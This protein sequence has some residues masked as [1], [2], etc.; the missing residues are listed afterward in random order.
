[1][2]VELKLLLAPDDLEKLPEIEALRVLREG[3][4]RVQR[5][6]TRYYDTPARDLARAGIALRVRRAGEAWIQTIKAGGRSAGGL[7]ERIELEWTIADADL[8]F[9]RLAD[10]PYQ[11]FFADAQLRQALQPVYETD[12]ERV[13]IQLV[14]PDGARAELALDRGEVRSGPRAESISEAEIE[15][16]GGDAA[17]LFDLAAVIAQHVPLR[18]GYLSKAERGD[19]L[20]TGRERP[21]AKAT[22][23]ELT[24]ECT[25]AQALARIGLS[26]LE[27]IQANEAGV[28][29]ASD[30][31]YLHQLRVGLRRLRVLVGLL[32]FVAPKSAFA[33]DAKALRALS[34][35]LN[36]ARDWDV[37]VDEMLPT[38]DQAMP[39]K[40]EIAARAEKLRGKHRAKAREALRA[41]GYGQLM[42]RLAQRFNDPALGLGSSGKK[43]KR[44]ALDAPVEDLAA[45]ALERYDRKLRKAGARLA[46][47]D[48]KG[49][50]ALRIRAKKLRY[51]A[52]FFAALYPAGRVKP[53][54]AALR[55]LQ[56][57]LGTLG[58][59]AQYRRLSAK[60]VD[61]DAAEAFEAI[62]RWIDQQRTQELGRC[63]ECWR[64][65]EET[66]R[67]W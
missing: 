48:D 37:Y 60:A 31:E 8:D 59:L 56:D 9:D 11:R 29:A 63:A 36:K 19:A 25:V 24:P 41:P 21:P 40:D 18:L 42:L 34:K 47:A 61:R 33:A 43:A 1:M 16:I 2:E 15:L 52:E 49:R 35:S 67:F 22:A 53:Y 28:L 32:R 50:H 64:A 10:T 66:P 44:I 62:D 54:V 17:R 65:F 58:D 39:Q 14:W 45:A 3:E 6:H 55:R 27:H 5:L 23:I 30:G 13:A 46:E 26:C 38:A 4:L 7:H 57:A 51:V 20:A 12:F